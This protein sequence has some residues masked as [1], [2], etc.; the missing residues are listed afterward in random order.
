MNETMNDALTKAIYGVSEKECKM[1]GEFRFLKSIFTNGREDEF[2]IDCFEK[3]QKV[4]RN[5]E[6]KGHI[7]VIDE[8]DS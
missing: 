5:L 7:E 6:S 3:V 4:L 2:C 8:Y 1:C